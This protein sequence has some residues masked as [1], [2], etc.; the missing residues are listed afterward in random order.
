MAPKKK[1]NK[2]TSTS[3]GTMTKWMKTFLDHQPVISPYG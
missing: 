2:G 3:G 1:K